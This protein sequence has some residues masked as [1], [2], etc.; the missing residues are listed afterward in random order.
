[1]EKSLKVAWMG[2]QVELGGVSENHQGRVTSISYI[3]GDSEMM[4]SWVFKGW[5][6]AQKMNNA[7]FQHFCPEER[8][9]SNCHPEAKQLSS[10]PQVTG[11][12]QAAAPEPQIKC[13]CHRI[14]LHTGFL[15]GKSV[16]LSPPSHSAAIS[17]DFHG[18]A[19]SQH[20]N[21]GLGSPVWGQDPLLSWKHLCS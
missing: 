2:S 14:S 11:M 6:K 17:T 18:Q 7:L 16:T 21:H 13:I 1:M 5:G 12:F 20:W 8:C 3:D 9:F 19:I 10:S 4:P 15:K